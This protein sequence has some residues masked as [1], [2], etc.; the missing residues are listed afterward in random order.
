VG[1][2]GA[3]PT[4]PAFIQ[5]MEDALVEFKLELLESNLNPGKVFESIQKASK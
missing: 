4:P 1:E 3:I 5:A 2:A